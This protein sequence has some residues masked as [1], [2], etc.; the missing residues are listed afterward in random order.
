MEILKTIPESPNVNHK[1]EHLVIYL[2]D[3]IAVVRVD[4]PV[5][6]FNYVV[7]VD[8]EPIL[9]SYTLSQRLIIQEFLKKIVSSVMNIELSKIPSVLE[10]SN[11]KES[12]EKFEE[13]LEEKPEEESEG[14]PEEEPEE[15]SEE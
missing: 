11:V 2:N 14:E 9:E 1:I 4:V 3:N 5:F 10:I 15:E 7:K 6:P 13:K 12:E 8:L